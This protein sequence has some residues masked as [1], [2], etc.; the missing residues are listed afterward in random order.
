MHTQTQVHV[1]TKHTLQ[2]RRTRARKKILKRY[3]LGVGHTANNVARLFHH[4]IVSW[5]YYE[6]VLYL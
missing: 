6:T 2:E 5:F 3:L 4:R 1:L